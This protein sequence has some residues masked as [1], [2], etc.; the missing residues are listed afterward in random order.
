MLL[1]TRD[2]RKVFSL[3]G[4]EVQALRGVSVDL[5]EGRIIGL[6]GPNGAGKS[7][8]IKLSL[9]YLIPTSGSITLLNEPPGS[10]KA[11][12]RI[13]YLPEHASFPLDLKGEELLTYVG[14]LFGKRGKELKRR[15][16]ELLERVGLKEAGARRIG[17]Y[18]KGMMQRLGLAQALIGD[19]YLLI[20]DEPMTGLDPVGRREVK[21]LLRELHRSGVSIFF[22][23]HILEDVE[24]LCHDLIVIVGGQIRYAGSLP[25]L[26]LSGPAVYS[27]TLRTEDPSLLP[28]LPF[29][30]LGEG[31]FSA[32]N[33]DESQYAVLL[34][35]L[36]EK[37]GLSL[38]E[39]KRS[40]R[41][42]EERFMEF[43]SPSPS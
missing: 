4:R 33:L 1:T 16:W 5:P 41:S 42:L 36:E 18:S 13:G 26:L 3:K 8:L 34:R 31:I 27:A 6:I 14:M 7:T 10:L 11:L 22:S 43:L 21:E 20:L 38:L 19:P 24:H 30:P 9:G 37:P 40:Y 12:S 29:R 39:L 15:V 2:L 32:E 25:E 23:S 28:S 35:T 17:S